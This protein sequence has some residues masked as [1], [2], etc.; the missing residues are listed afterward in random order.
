MD[1]YRKHSLTL[2]LNSLVGSLQRN[3][4]VATIA[5]IYE[6]TLDTFSH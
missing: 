1:E 5:V 4:A 3:T 2:L 6:C